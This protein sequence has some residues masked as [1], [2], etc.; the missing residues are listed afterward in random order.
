MI[1]LCEKAD[2]ARL[3][4][5]LSNIFLTDVR[6]RLRRTSWT[7]ASAFIRQPPS[8]EKKNK[9]M[10]F[11]QRKTQTCSNNKPNKN[12]HA[13]IVLGLKTF[14]STRVLN[15]HVNTSECM[16]ENSCEHKRLTLHTH[17]SI[18]CGHYSAWRKLLHVL[19]VIKPVMCT[20]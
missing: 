6:R 12:I 7:S 8:L 2:A 5:A 19:I 18:R 3:D 16:G 10:E 1:N 14:I 9:N 17:C 13:Y 15:R 11:Y 20:R 4:T